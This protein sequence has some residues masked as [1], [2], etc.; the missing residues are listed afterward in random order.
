MG[1]DKPIK[2]A[3]LCNARDIVNRAGRFFDDQ[4]RLLILER[5][6][7]DPGS[8]ESNRLRPLIDREIQNLKHLLFA[9]GECQIT[10]LDDQTITVTLEEFEQRASI[11]HFVRMFSNSVEKLLRAGGAANLAAKH[12]RV[13]CILT[14][15]GSTTPFIRKLFEQPMRMDQSNIA[16]NIVN[17]TPLWVETGDEALFQTYPQM[18]VAMGGCDPSLPKE[19]QT[20]NDITAPGTVVRVGSIAGGYRVATHAT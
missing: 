5:A 17:P 7:I 14:G 9:T 4:L 1:T 2:F 6:G 11:G 10:L 3:S 20:I 8:P 18:A 16:F 13:H 15:G 19:V 12:N